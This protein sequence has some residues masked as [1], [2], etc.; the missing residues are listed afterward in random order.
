MAVTTQQA[1]NV[2][3]TV[4]ARFGSQSFPCNKLS[5]SQLTAG[6]KKML[7][8]SMPPVAT[9]QVAVQEIVHSGL[10]GNSSKWKRVSTWA[11]QA[12]PHRLTSAQMQFSK[13]NALDN[14]RI[15]VERRRA[16]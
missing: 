12:Y 8:A 5:L 13:V 1:T 2:N 6:F 15:Q 16:G 4:H 10:Y 14:P 11:G 7:K 9:L 3:T